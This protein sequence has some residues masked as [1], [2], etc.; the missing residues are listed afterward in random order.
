MIKILKIMLLIFI[1]NLIEKKNFINYNISI[2]LMKA[3]SIIMINKWNN[4][5]QIN[6]II[7]R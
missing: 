6:L 4:Y 2:I 1:K 5:N 7:Y 3:R